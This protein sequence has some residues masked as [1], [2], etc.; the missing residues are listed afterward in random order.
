MLTS[1]HAFVD[2]VVYLDQSSVKHFV[3]TFH[4]LL[5]FCQGADTPNLSSV[6]ASYTFQSRSEAN[7]MLSTLLTCGDD[8]V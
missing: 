6:R 2:L 4:H 5:D 1:A 7:E 3:V 8:D